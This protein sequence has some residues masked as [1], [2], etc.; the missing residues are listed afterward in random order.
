VLGL[1]VAAVIVGALVFILGKPFGGPAASPSPSAAGSPVAYGDGTCP[2]S[3][4]ASLAAGEM[5][6]VTVQTE[7]GAIVMQ[8]DGSRAPIA[9]GNF[10]ALVQCHYYDGLTFHRLVPGFVI[11]GGDPAGDGSG[12]PGYTIKDD[13]LNGTYKRGTIAMARTAQPESQGSQ[14]F[15]VLADDANTALTDPSVRYPYAI[16]GEVTSGMDV[17]DAIA[18]MPNTGDANGNAAVDPVVMTSV[19]VAPAASPAPSALPSASASTGPT[20]GPSASP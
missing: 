5:R 7:K 16:L 17:V 12:G 13:P 20:L 2:T 6:T 3:Q 14:F 8:I 18:A 10:I 19:T 15:I 9:T 1:A 11:Q 4:P